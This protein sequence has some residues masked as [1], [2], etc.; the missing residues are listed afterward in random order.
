VAL[1]EEVMSALTEQLSKIR[2][3]A[4]GCA[5]AGNQA[6]DPQ[7]KQMYMRLADHLTSL[8][9]EVERAVNESAPTD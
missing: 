6:T 5:L 7:K 8:A 4:E 9:A 2:A 1:R 3:E